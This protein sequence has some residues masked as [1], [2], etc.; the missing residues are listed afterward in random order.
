MAR[1]ANAA[2]VGTDATLI[3]DS[4]GTFF[5]LDKPIP[6][7]IEK[8]KD[9]ITSLHCFVHINGIQV[10]TTSN[11]GVQTCFVLFVLVDAW[12]FYFYFLV[13]R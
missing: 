2:H 5:I 7:S 1:Q 6:I 9:W 3:E 13:R 8:Y 10:F 11:H 4:K 12:L